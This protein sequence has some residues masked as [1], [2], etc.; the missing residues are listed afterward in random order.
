VRIPLFVSPSTY[1]FA[2]IVITLAAF[3]SGMVVRRGVDRLDLIEVLKTK[4]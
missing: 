2:V 3:V 1:A 4:G